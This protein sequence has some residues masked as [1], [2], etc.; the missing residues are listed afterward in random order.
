MET[1]EYNQSS[2]KEIEDMSPEAD[3]IKGRALMDAVRLC[4][5]GSVRERMDLALDRI[6]LQLSIAEKIIKK[7]NLFSIYEMCLRKI[8]L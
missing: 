7:H 8:G 3:L 4:P 1:A 2:V 5:E 6:A